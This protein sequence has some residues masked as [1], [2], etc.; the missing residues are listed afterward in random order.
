MPLVVGSFSKQRPHVKVLLI[1]DRSGYLGSKF[2]KEEELIY[3]LSERTSVPKEL[4]DQMIN[5]L[6]DIIMETV[7][8]GKKVKIDRFGILNAAQDLKDKVEI[9]K[10]ERFLLFQQLMLSPFCRRNHLKRN[11][12][13]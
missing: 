2:M 6:V 8:D 13:V 3:A 11:S 1:R 4:A 9:Q 7:S 5:T 12:I 10:L